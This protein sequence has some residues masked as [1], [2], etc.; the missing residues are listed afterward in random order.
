MLICLPAADAVKAKAQ[1]EAT[2]AEMTV[3]DGRVTP[4]DPATVSGEDAVRRRDW[5]IGEAG[6]DV[7]KDLEDEGAAD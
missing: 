7:E 4:E 3:A 5:E 2:A 6:E 1:S